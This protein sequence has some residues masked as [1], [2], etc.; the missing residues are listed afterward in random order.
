MANI[1]CR[2]TVLYEASDHDGY[3][4]GSE[5][6]YVKKTLKF[7]IE[8]D[9]KP[10]EYMRNI[11]SRI[12]NIVPNVI[13]YMEGRKMYEEPSFG[14]VKGPTDYGSGYCSNSCDFIENHRFILTLKKI[15]YLSW[16]RRKYALVGYWFDSPY[17][18]LYS[19]DPL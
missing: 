8:G 11:M 4:S 12:Q 16:K 17:S 9:Q 10:E 2:I 18:S 1:K 3:C 15:D 6:E 19:P 14:I 7:N 5:C 13:S